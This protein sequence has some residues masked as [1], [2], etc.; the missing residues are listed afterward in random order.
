MTTFVM[1]FL[2]LR[3]LHK[4]VNV[5]AFGVINGIWKVFSCCLLA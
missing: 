5:A 3:V 2:F 1:G 4:M